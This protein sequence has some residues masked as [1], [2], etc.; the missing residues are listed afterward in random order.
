M[1]FHIRLLENCN[2]RCSSCYARNRDKKQMINFTDFKD[3][4]NTIKQIQETDHN[5]SVIYLSG[6][7]P[8]LHPRFL[9]FLEYCFSQFDRVSILTNGTLVKR[10]MDNFIPYSKKLCVQVSLDGDE[11]TN[12]AIR[13]KGV[14]KKAV[15]ALHM[16]E[17]NKLR[18][19]MSY[20]VSQSNKHCYKHIINVGKE[21]NSLFNNVT[22]YIGEQ[23][24]M[25]D[26]YEWKEFKYNFEKYTRSLNLEFAHG[27]NCCGFNYN[28]GAF[29]AGV[30][31]NPDGSL[32]GCARIND[33]VGHYRDMAKFLLPKSRSIT[34]TCMKEKWHNFSYFNTI[35][36]LE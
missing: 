34:E 19:W 8:L 24:K 36:Y 33:V 14:Y 35:Q 1:W 17:K 28:C 31:V 13:G 29:S 18:H 6:G 22:P 9:D 3:I 11:E 7:E 26:Y 15:E 20:T 16:L 2:L 32:A 5:M 4:L 21:T 25:L 23:D 12:D 30:T 10:F 27:P